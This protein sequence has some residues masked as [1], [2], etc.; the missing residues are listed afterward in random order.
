MDV[1]ISYAFYLKKRI[2]VQYQ[3]EAEFQPAGILWY[4]EDLKRGLNAESEPKDFFEMASNLNWHI[5]TEADE[6]LPAD[7]SF[8][9]R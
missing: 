8:R 7:R 2:L 3:G 5:G 6:W 1:K 4:V 9:H